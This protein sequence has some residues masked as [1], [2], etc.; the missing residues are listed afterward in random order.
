MLRASGLPSSKLGLIAVGLQQSE[1]PDTPWLG[2]TASG[3]P[4]GAFFIVVS[5]PG[6]PGA[7]GSSTLA[8]PFTVTPD[9][10]AVGPLYHQVFF[11]DADAPTAASA[12]TGC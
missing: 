8:I 3:W 1:L 7:P 9:L 2:S 11:A 6:Q 12:A 4:W 5:P 10:P